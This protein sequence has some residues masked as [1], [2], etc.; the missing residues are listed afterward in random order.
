M[1]NMEEV[2]TKICTK[3]HKE[4]PAT[5]E[6]FYKNGNKLRPE[7]KKCSKKCDKKRSKAYYIKN[8]CKIRK[9]HKENY[10][11]IK[12]RIFNHYGHE[13]KVCKENNF[14]LLCIDHINND[15]Y[16]YKIHSGIA[17]YL[18]L[19]RNN[20][21][22]GFQVLCFNCNFK[23][24]LKHKKEEHKHTK[25]SERNTIRRS[26]LKVKIFSH[27]GSKCKCCGQSEIDVLTINHINNNGAE[28]RKEIK[29]SC[30]DKFYYW[31]I[32]NN[33][34]DDLQVLCWNCNLGRQFH[35]GICP[36]IIGGQK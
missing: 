5:T 22:P 35:D 23:K 17:T 31:I 6:N 1:S 12:T 18:W 24:E 28:H 19:I 36:H 2:K 21:P 30:V 27:Y 13:C 33:F 16:K 14:D 15:R 20:F 25:Y 9:R 7:C 26:K 4:K 32:K 11:N 3:C 34:P 10:D 29:L 8:K